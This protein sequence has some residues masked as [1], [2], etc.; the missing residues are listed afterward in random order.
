MLFCV[1][2]LLDFVMYY[3]W[4]ETRFLAMFWHSLIFVL[5]L[6]VAI[7]VKRGLSVAVVVI[8]FSNS[9]I[10]HAA[11]TCL[12]SA[13]TFGEAQVALQAVQD[14]TLFFYCLLLFAL[15]VVHFIVY[16]M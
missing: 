15:F 6:C 3:L 7:V 13:A 8:S 5:P 14:C 11:I 4:V 12:S 16:I 2:S 10:I 1:G 9:K